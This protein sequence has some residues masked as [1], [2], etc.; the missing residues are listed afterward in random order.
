VVIN[1]LIY[2]VFWLSLTLLCVL[3]LLI[4]IPGPYFNLETLKAVIVLP[5]GFFFMLGSLFRIF[6]AKRSFGHTTHTVQ[7]EISLKEK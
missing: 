4:S 6:K 2:T 1:P 5:K 7:K 3:T